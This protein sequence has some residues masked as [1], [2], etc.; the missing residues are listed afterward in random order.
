MRGQSGKADPGAEQ[1]ALQQPDHDDA[2]CHCHDDGV[3]A[4]AD[5]VTARTV[6]RR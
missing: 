5:D 6:R 2:K 4:G 3:G 1:D